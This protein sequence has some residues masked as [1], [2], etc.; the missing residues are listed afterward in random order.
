MTE[1]N[2][3]LAR[4][5]MVEQQ[6]RPWE[7]LDQR[8]LDVIINTPREQFVPEE[9]KNLAFADIEIPIGHGERMMAPKIEGRMLQALNVK[10]IDRVLEIGTGT[11][12]MTTCLAKLA[13]EVVTVDIQA[14]FSEQ[15]EARLAAMNISNVSYRVGDAAAGWEEDG[16]FDVI[17]VTGSL[18]K[19][20]GALKRKL[21]IGGRMF[22][23]IGDGS[24]TKA[25]MEA[26][27]VTRVNPRDWA[28]ESLFETELRALKNTVMPANFVF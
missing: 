5:N 10:S 7:V 25:T 6:I 14:E 8:V 24:K 20:S 21:T 19:M 1:V 28:I 26:L 18:P 22:V 4:N 2:I 3:E 15:A 11:G 13:A 12:F 23:V 9:Y 16:E 17:A 27:L